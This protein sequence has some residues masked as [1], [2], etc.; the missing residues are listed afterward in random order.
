MVKKPK[1]VKIQNKNCL[2][3]LREIICTN[4]IEIYGILEQELDH[5]IIVISVLYKAKYL[6]LVS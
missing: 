4:Y 3:V 2:I 6:Y 5:L 1:N